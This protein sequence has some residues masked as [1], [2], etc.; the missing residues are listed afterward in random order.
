MFQ[1]LDNDIQLIDAG[2]RVDKLSTNESEI[3]AASIIA[4][5]IADV[6]S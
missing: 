4:E 2:L 1:T 3:T 5:V 6:A